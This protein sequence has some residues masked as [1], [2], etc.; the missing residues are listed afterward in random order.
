MIFFL[1]LL[2]PQNDWNFH[3]SGDVRSLSPLHGIQF[4]YHRVYNSGDRMT[5][6]GY[7]NY[8]H[9]LANNCS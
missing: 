2:F 7:H 1:I 3:E 9:C 5:Y 6:R 8:L 4:R